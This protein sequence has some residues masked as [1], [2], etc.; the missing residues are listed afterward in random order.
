MKNCPTP[1]EISSY[2][3]EELSPDKARSV[4]NHLRECPVCR[5]LGE[6][7]NAS[8]RALQAVAAALAAEAPAGA[9][10]P[11]EETLLAYADGSSN[12]EERKS[13]AAHLVACERCAAI[14]SAAG[15]TAR[16]CREL[17]RDGM[18]EAPPG[19]VARARER[20]FPKTPDLIGEITVSL[21]NLWRQFQ[22]GLAYPADAIMAPETVRESGLNAYDARMAATI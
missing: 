14:A 22:E 5:E 6:S 8:R 10:C 16:L 12:H 20:F 9:D 11:D 2:T 19:L 21:Q 7:L 3:D 13:I 18:E 4:A 15:Q 1:E 17:D